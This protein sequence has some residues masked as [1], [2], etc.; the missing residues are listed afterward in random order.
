MVQRVRSYRDGKG[1]ELTLRSERTVDM[2]RGLWKLKLE[3]FR[4]GP[5]GNRRIARKLLSKSGSWETS[6][7][8]FVFAQEEAEFLLSQ[9]VEGVTM[10]DLL[11]GRP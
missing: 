5:L 1:R 4:R 11:E 10:V 7:I 6:A 2:E 9:G 3:L 8:R